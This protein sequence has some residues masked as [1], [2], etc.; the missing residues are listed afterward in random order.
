MTTPRNWTHWVEIPVVD[1]SR[2]KRFYE[3]LF[4]IELAVQDFGG[5]KMA[6]FPHLEVGVAL[7]IGKEYRP[8]A[9]GVLVYL[10]ANPDLQLVLAK[11]EGAGG[12]I[13]QVKKQISETHG[14]MALLIDS[15]GNRIALHSMG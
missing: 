2:A 8:S 15:E 11:V 7:C 4:G 1:I 10:D 5:F 12:E 9:D 3:E 14:F 6:I 13:L